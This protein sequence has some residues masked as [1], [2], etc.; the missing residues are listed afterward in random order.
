MGCEIRKLVNKMENLFIYA[1]VTILNQI[2]RVYK[3]GHV[4]HFSGA[5]VE[6]SVNVFLTLPYILELLVTFIR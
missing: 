6:I 2:L 1:E 3:V 4:G 5:Y